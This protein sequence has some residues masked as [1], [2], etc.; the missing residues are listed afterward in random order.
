MTTVDRSFDQADL[1]LFNDI[2]A[3]QQWLDRHGRDD[4]AYLAQLQ[5]L[6]AL[7]ARQHALQLRLLTALL[8]TPGDAGEARTL[9]GALVS[10]GLIA[11]D[12]L[13]PALQ[14]TLA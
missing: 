11:R 8:D 1:E 3:T 6:G 14:A 4:P 7:V 5:R 10:R 13:S 12:E 9:L 2:A